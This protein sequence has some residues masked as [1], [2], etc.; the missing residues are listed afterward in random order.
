MRWLDG[1]TD[2]MNMSLSRLWGLVMGR[3]NWRATYS[4]WGH[5]ELDKTEQL[6]W[7]DPIKLVSSF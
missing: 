4:P 3:E 1:I 5:K 7:T 2:M 6:N